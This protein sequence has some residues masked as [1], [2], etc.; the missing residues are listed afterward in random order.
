LSDYWW[1]VDFA[2][3]RDG[4]WRDGPLVASWLVAK[5]PGGE[6]TGYQRCIC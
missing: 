4:W 2:W 6:M 5:L 1:R 3:W